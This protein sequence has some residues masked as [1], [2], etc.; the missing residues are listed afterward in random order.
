MRNHFDTTRFA[1]RA[2]ADEPQALQKLID[3]FNDPTFASVAI[4]AGIGLLAGLV[5]AICG[6]P[7][8]W[9]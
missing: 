1:D 6:V 2:A 9:M 4:F 8:V 5:A 7:G 3:V